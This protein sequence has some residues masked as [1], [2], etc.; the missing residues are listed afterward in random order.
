VVTL[1]E[2]LHHELKLNAAAIRVSVLCPSFVQTGIAESE[3][4]RPPELKPATQPF[5]PRDER[6]ARAMKDAP[7][8]ADEVAEM[9]LEA[10]MRGSFYILPHGDVRKGVARRAA[11][12]IED[13]EPAIGRLPGA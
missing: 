2:C 11:A 6:L 7:L 5:A 13:R 1:S 8:S 10:V 9:T 4:H 3:R 12:L